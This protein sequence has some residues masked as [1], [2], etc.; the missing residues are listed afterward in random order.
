MVILL[1]CE[2]LSLLVSREGRRIEDD[3]I[4]G[5]TLFAKAVQPMKGV[6]LAEIVARSLDRGAVLKCS[7]ELNE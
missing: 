5:A 3:A 4:E 6:S 7:K 2:N 1:H